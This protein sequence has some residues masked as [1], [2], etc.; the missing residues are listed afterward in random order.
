VVATAEEEAGGGTLC[1]GSQVGFLQA[2]D[3]VHSVLS[4][5]EATQERTP[6]SDVGC[7]AHYV[8]RGPFA[9][10]AEGR[11]P[12]LS[13]SL[14]PAGR[15]NKIRKQP[16]KDRMG[17]ALP[18]PATASTQGV[19]ITKFAGAT[20]PG[21]QI[22]R[23]LPDRDRIDARRDLSTAEVVSKNTT[24]VCRGWRWGCCVGVVDRCRGW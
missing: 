5:M 17:A 23:L 19:Q 3:V 4:G 21:V 20:L 18:P 2:Y 9:R 8:P 15:I 10:I 22:S 6:P 1:T 12:L 11:I 7:E 14:D 13:P 16:T 24:P